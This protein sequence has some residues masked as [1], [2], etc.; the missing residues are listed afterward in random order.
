M[1]RGSLFNLNDSP[2]SE[3]RPVSGEHVQT[4]DDVGRIRDVL[5]P[6]LVHS[7]T[8]EELE[9]QWRFRKELISLSLTILL[10]LVIVGGMLIYARVQGVTFTKA[11]EFVKNLAPAREPE[12][13]ATEPAPAPAPPKK[14][15]RR[16]SSYAGVKKTA[17]E[18]PASA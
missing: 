5:G 11:V 6:K 4:S 17:A 16:S 18:S 9:R 10:V 7:H 13:V 3:D 15:S 12:T 14:A 1:D 2:T 8:P